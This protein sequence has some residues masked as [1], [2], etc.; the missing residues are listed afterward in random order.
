MPDALC[1]DLAMRAIGSKLNMDVRAGTLFQ[2]AV[3]EGISISHEALK[4]VLLSCEQDGNVDLALS[5]FMEVLNGHQRKGWLVRGSELS[6]RDVEEERETNAV[7]LEEMG[8]FVAAVLRICNATHNYGLAISCLRLFALEVSPLQDHKKRS[9]QHVLPAILQSNRSEDLLLATMSAFSGLRCPD[10]SVQLCKEFVD[11]HGID[12]DYKRQEIKAVYDYCMSQTK[13][14]MAS[15][16]LHWKTADQHVMNLFELVH[17]L[18]LVPSKEGLPK[19][20]PIQERLG[21]AMSA[22]TD[23][24][25]PKLALFLLSYVKSRCHP[26]RATS[27]S[28]LRHLFGLDSNEN[29]LLESILEEDLL[30]AEEIKN[31]VWDKDK[32]KA[33]KLFYE[34]VDSKSNELDKWPLSCEA[35][36]TA[37]I[38][39]GQTKDAEL[40][41]KAMDPS[42]LSPGSYVPVAHAFVANEKWDDLFALYRHSL[43]SKNLTDELALVTMAGIVSSD[44]PDKLGRLRTVVDD[45]SKKGK[46]E[47]AEWIRSRYWLLKKRLGFHHTRLLMWW[48]DRETSDMAELDFCIEEFHSGRASDQRER[49]ESTKR[50]VDGCPSAIRSRTNAFEHIPGSRKDWMELL[51][52]ID[53]EAASV[54]LHNDPNF[55]KAMVHANREIDSPSGARKVV[56]AALDRSVRLK[57]ETLEEA[58]GYVTEGDLARDI[59]MLVGT[60][61]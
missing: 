39:N 30:K 56:S 45:V 25:Q 17:D 21:A 59:E 10:I 51:R 6:T 46:V 41:F 29:D 48:N 8:G 15:S 54:Q 42:H 35:G 16:G 40:I 12:N 49:R 18:R 22:C 23:A 61:R 7:D 27:F 60:A 32:E 37:L 58:R 24:R 36:L 57:R 1:R 55:L 47:P 50:I 38:A 14:H 3:Q 20:D 43:R 53:K 4:G 44:V 28:T 34:I 13:V 31:T 26:K 52:R 33:V 19:L 5:I 9:T 11:Q 2:M